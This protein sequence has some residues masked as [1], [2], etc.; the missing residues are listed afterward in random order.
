MTSMK[1]CYLTG[2]THGQI[3]RFKQIKRFCKKK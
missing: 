1:H 2:D 3:G